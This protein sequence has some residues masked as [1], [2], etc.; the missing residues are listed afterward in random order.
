[1]FCVINCSKAVSYLAVRGFE[2]LNV[3]ERI[4]LVTDITCWYFGNKIIN[5]KAKVFFYSGK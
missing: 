1:M 5:L 3:I 2:D 4:A